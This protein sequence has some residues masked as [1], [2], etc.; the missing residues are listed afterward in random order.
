MYKFQQEYENIEVLEESD[1]ELTIQIDDDKYKI[2]AQKGTR[3]KRTQRLVK[4]LLMP[5]V[6][7]GQALNEKALRR[8][9]A[10]DKAELKRLQKIMSD[11]AKTEDDKKAAEESANELFERYM[12]PDEYASLVD[13]IYDALD[14]DQEA[15]LDMAL[16]TDVQSIADGDL[17]KQANF[18]K[19][20]VKHRLENVDILRDVVIE[21]NGFL[22][23]KGSRKSG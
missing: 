7:K 1:L 15:A 22:D 13:G 17:S 20:F 3:G 19:H 18:D 11:D 5:Q 6:A 4:K 2:L 23:P 12:D 9:S 14:P 8:M 16:M 21:F 10:E